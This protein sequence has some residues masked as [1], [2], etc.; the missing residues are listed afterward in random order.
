MF[1]VLYGEAL[2]QDGTLVW[3]DDLELILAD[4]GLDQYVTIAAYE[5][6]FQFTATLKKAMLLVAF[7][8]IMLGLALNGTSHIVPQTVIHWIP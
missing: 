2:N 5:G 3:S 1:D 8:G 6:G 7:L 4:S